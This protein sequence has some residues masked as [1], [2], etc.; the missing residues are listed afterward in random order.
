ML[1]ISVCRS[2]KMIERSIYQL[3]GTITVV[4]EKLQQ[5]LDFYKPYTGL[6]RWDYQCLPFTD[7]MKS[8]GCSCL[9]QKWTVCNSW[10]SCGL[11]KLTKETSLICSL[12]LTIYSLMLNHSSNSIDLS[13]LCALHALRLIIYFCY[14]TF[15]IQILLRDSVI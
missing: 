1:C 10:T 5:W 2:L 11:Q 3:S 9:C 14:N 4:Y 7:G 6:N 12:I 8:I 15:I 13:L